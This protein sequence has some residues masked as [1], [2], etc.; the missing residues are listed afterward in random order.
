MWQELRSLTD[1][2]FEQ[3][4]AKERAV[5]DNDAAQQAEARAILDELATLAQGDA[6]TLRHAETRIAALNTR[7]RA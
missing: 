5:A 3:A 1:P 6:D 4:T 2:W 7:W